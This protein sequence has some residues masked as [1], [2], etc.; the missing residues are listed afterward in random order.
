MYNLG[1]MF[2]Y[3]RFLEEKIIKSL[4]KGTM[5]T[6]L[7]PRQAGKTT[8][9]KSILL[10]FGVEGQYFDCQISEVRDHFIPGNPKLLKELVGDKKVV[11]FD[12]AQTVQDIGLILK[13]FH[14]T[15]PEVQVIASGSS[16]FDLANKVNEPMT[17]RVFEFTLLPLS[18]KELSQTETITKELLYECMLYGMYPAVVAAKDRQ[19]RELV[20]KNLVTNYLYKDVFIFENIRNPR[21]FEQLVKQLAYQVGQPVSI[22]ELALSLGISRSVVQKYIRLLEQTFIIKVIHSFSENPRLELKK[23]F[24]IYFYDNG[25]RNT[26]TGLNTQ[27]ENRTDK[28][29]ILENLFL[30]EKLKSYTLDTFPPDMMMWRTKKG[31]EVDFVEKDGFAIEAFECKWSE[32]D[33]SF[34]LFLKKYP[35]SK[36]NIITPEYFINT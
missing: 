3:K 33:V 17:G 9:C 7:G 22:N 25:L 30:T 36:T 13:V 1:Y 20:L 12:E 11:V 24:K 35:N 28:G 31:L 8:L 5:I 6:I 27:L 15:Y 21:I 34:K 26:L 29:F 2:I 4:H 32:Q 18:I 10:P 23:A 14:D 19:E 16:S